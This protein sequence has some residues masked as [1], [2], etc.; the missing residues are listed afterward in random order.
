MSV[1]ATTAA[2]L[3]ASEPAGADIVFSGADQESSSLIA[4][5]ERETFSGASGRRGS[6]GPTC[7]WTAFPDGFGQNPANPTDSDGFAPGTREG[8]GGPE[9]LWYRDCDDGASG[10]VY[11]PTVDPAE[12]RA[13]AYDRVSEQLPTPELA[14]RPDP[15]NGSLIRMQNWLAVA[16][17]AD[18]SATAAVGPV[19]VTVTAAPG[20]TSWDMGNGDIVECDGVGTPLPAG[21]DDM[22]D[23]SVDGAAPCGYAYPHVSAPEFGAG[24]DLAY[25]NAVTLDWSIRWTDH[26]GAGGTLDD[27]STTT[28][29]SIRVRQIQTVRS[30]G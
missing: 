29:W 20:D 12:L 4:S 27:L 18:V 30:D 8:A 10:L 19:W 25:D 1:L 16:P 5:A 9:A 24:P 15:A 28:G 17:P 26:T 7:R 6:V 14:I 22:L 3:T 21:V 11:V 2:L 13:A 23:E